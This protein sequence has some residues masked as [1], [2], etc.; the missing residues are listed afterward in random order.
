M[1]P[2]L[3][4]FSFSLYVD[5]ALLDAELAVNRA[6]VKMLGKIRLIK[7]PEVKRLLS[8][9][10]AV[11]REL[12]PKN[13]HDKLPQPLLDRY[14]DVHTLIQATL[15]KKIG[16]LAKK[17]HT[18]RSRNDLVVTSTR[19][20]L[21]E[22]IKSVTVKITATQKALVGCAKKTSDA[23]LPG[24]THLK[25]AQPILLAHHLLAY[26]AMME[27]DKGRIQDA[28][29]RVDVLPLGSAALAGSSLPI[30]QKFLA[31]ELGFSKIATNSIAAVSDRALVTEVVSHLAI[32]WMHLSR[33]A[34]D[35]ILWNSEFFGFVELDDAF[36]TGSS[37]MPQKKNP[38]VF[39]L[40]RGR[41]GVIF[42]YLQSLLVMQKGL[43]LAYNRDLQEDKPALFDAINKTELALEVLA[44]TL[45]S[46]TFNKKAM[47]AATQE[48][49][50]F[51]TDVLEYLVRKHVPFTEAHETV[52]KI[53]RQAEELGRPVRELSL[54]EW[55]FFNPAFNQDIYD[56][57]E[58]KTSVAAKKTIGSTNPARVKS[59]I[60][61]WEK[62]LK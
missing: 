61:N 43:P 48:D 58:P 31:R 1:H 26:V 24:L 42:G 27:G 33:L 25:K 40:V 50:L 18:A 39:E 11:D 10:R 35:F 54:K 41:A 45:S 51:A 53:L 30:D 34:E 32:L 28:Q 13:S 21:R 52:G 46:A 3:K 19:L 22:K 55:R 6:W 38:D 49:S 56:L 14:E 17:L 12:R 7:Q 29:K 8:G 16:R 23:V 15:E 60:R 44:L 4:C 59:E 62:S 20:Y 9:L 37:L 5:F 57:F 2:V 36:S 47:E